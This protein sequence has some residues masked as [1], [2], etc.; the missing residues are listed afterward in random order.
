[1]FINQSLSQSVTL[2]DRKLHGQ[3]CNL[4]LDYIEFVQTTNKTS[5]GNCHSITRALS[6]HIK[7]LRT[8]DGW[9]VGLE[10]GGEKPSLK[11]TPHSWLVTPDEAII[12]PYPVGMLIPNPAL[13]PTRSEYAHSGAGYYLSNPLI[14]VRMNIECSSLRVTRETAVITQLMKQAI[15]FAQNRP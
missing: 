8:V 4:L 5:R 14:T 13:I 10:M 9:Y 6:S 7:E 11:Y 3:V 2:A 15:I 12:E 1:M